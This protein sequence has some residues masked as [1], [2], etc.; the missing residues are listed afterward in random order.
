MLH[1]LKGIATI[2]IL[3]EKCVIMALFQACSDETQSA[4][5][6]KNSPLALLE[7]VGWICGKADIPQF[8]VRD[9][10]RGLGPVAKHP[11]GIPPA[12]PPS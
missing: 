12:S 5:I 7:K 1:R 6:Y 2:A 8:L 10:Y 11:Y 4:R 3:I 9:G